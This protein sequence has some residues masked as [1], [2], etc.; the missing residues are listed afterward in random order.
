MEKVSL[1]RAKKREGLIRAR[2]LGASKAV[3]DVLIFLDSHCECAEGWIEPLVDPIARN[4]NV[5]TVPLIEIIDDNTFQLHSTPIESVQV[6]GFDWNL[7]FDWHVVP[8][9]EMQRRKSKVDPIRSV[10]CLN[11]YLFIFFNF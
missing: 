4:P 2:L 6:G 8:K 3:G 5:S 11:I 10:G 7:I 9:N 1:V